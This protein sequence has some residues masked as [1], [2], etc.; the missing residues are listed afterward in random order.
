[1]SGASLQTHT[2][3]I[4][5]LP[6]SNHDHAV[7][8]MDFGDHGEMYIMVGGVSDSVNVFFRALACF[9]LATARLTISLLY[10]RI[11]MPECQVNLHQDNLKSSF[12]QH[13]SLHIC[14]VQALTVL[15]YMMQTLNFLEMT[16]KYS[17]QA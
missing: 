14:I 2:P 13:A 17:R 4:S 7:N 3:V 8:G 5:G 10:F 9:L 1:V 11:Q 15:W 16:L 12:Q 6:V